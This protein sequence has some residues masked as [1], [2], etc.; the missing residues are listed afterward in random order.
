MVKSFEDMYNCLHR[1]LA[2]DGW[3]DRQTDRHVN[4]NMDLYS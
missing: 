2:C 4:V 1:M 3:M